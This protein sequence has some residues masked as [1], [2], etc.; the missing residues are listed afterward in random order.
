MPEQKKCASE[1]QCVGRRGH[2][3]AAVDDNETAVVSAHGGVG[4]RGSVAGSPAGGE[5][6]AGVVLDQGAGFGDQ[7]AQARINRL[8]AVAEGQKALAVLWGGVGTLL[9]RRQIHTPEIPGA[10]RSS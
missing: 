9:A 1:R 6:L 7:L 3:E 10:L 8:E 5:R 2:D 4:V